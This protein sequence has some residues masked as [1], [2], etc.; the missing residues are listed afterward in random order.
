M[1]SFLE[2]QN[3]F[4]LKSRQTKC[5]VLQKQQVILIFWTLYPTIVFW[6][7]HSKESAF[8]KKNNFWW[9]ENGYTICFKRKYVTVLCASTKSSIIGFNKTYVFLWPPWISKL[10]TI[11]IGHVPYYYTFLEYKWEFFFSLNLIVLISTRFGRT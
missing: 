5:M 2:Q 10:K 11:W 8:K 6:S 4:I 1:W 9:L 3:A 7:K